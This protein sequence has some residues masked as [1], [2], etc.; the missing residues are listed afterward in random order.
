MKRSVFLILLLLLA[1]TVSAQEQLKV[2]TYNLQGMRPGSNWQV[3]M[4][5]IVQYLEEL[6][7]DIICL[8]E[9]NETLTWGRRG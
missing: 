2:V 8:Q 5:Y 3:R 1:I 6:D 4:V 9:I 7:P